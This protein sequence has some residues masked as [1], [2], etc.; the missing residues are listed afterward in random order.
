[1]SYR[2]SSRGPKAGPLSRGPEGGPLQERDFAK[3]PRGGKRAMKG[4]GPGPL[5]WAP[6]PKPVELIGGAPAPPVELISGAPAPPVELIGGAPAPPVE[7]IGGAPAPPVRA[8][9]RNP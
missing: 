9:P 4:G 2:V 3:Y 6:H 1:M 7:L 5:A 8:R